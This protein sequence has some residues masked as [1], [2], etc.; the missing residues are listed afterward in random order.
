[1]ADDE[2]TKLEE[3]NAELTEKLKVEKDKAKANL[4]K[5]MTAMKESKEHQKARQKLEEE[6][7]ALKQTTA[8]AP[9]VGM[10]DAKADVDAAV[11]AAVEAAKADAAAAQE[12]AQRA[13]E[14]QV[15]QAQQR[16]A[17]EAAKQRVRDERRR[18]ALEA[19]R[20][21]SS[22]FVLPAVPQTTFTNVHDVT[23]GQESS[24]FRVDYSTHEQPRGGE[25][26]YSV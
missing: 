2:I 6:I 23:R 21:R 17:A 11:S 14:V 16:E 20:N 7:A 12:A 26:V 9:A 18:G 22:S 13:A 1:M 24:R 19:L 3:K 4:Q 5:F 15:V 25:T 8:A 10:P